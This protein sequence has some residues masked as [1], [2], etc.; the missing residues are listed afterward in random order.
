MQ[1]TIR[2]DEILPYV[3]GDYGQH[4]YEITN[5]LH[6]SGASSSIAADAPPTEAQRATVARWYLNREDR[7]AAPSRSL[8]AWAFAGMNPREVSTRYGD[9]RRIVHLS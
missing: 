8:C 2:Y 7:P 9:E 1:V 6:D 3:P 5:T 4:I